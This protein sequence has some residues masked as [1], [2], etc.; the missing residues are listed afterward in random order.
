MTEV[1]TVEDIEALML[2]TEQV[3]CKLVHH[4][5]PGVYIRELTMPKDTYVLGHKHK[6]PC[7]NIVSKGS[8]RLVDIETGEITFIKAP[9]TFESKAG[10]RKLAYVIEEC[11][12]SNVHPTIETDLDKLEEAIIDKS[13]TFKAVTLN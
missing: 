2:M 4:F 8:L 11:V 12:W 1:A 3:E 13:E 5:S 10:V 7:M 6:E 9:C